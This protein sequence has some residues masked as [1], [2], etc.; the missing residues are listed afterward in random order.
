MDVDYIVVA[1]ID[2]IPLGRCKAVDVRGRS[3][4]VAHLE[5][6]FHAVENRCSHAASGLD[7]S[8]VLKGGQILCPLHGARF[9]LRTGAAKTAPAFRPIAT[10]PCRVADGALEVAAP[11]K[12]VITTPP[13]PFGAQIG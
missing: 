3:V 2:D 12:P 9:D 8:R 5:D 10:Y 7:T 11:P 13:R 4:V 1:S 6:G